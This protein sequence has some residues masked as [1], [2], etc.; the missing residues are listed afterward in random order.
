[1]PLFRKKKISYDGEWVK[2]PSA[3]PDVAEFKSENQSGNLKMLSR[4]PERPKF[5]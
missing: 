4:R 3:D 5:F 1:M 2:I